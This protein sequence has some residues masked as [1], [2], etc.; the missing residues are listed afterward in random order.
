[1]LFILP[2]IPMTIDIF[3]ALVPTYTLLT[4][5]FIIGMS[6]LYTSLFN[7][8][9]L[10]AWLA[11]SILMASANVIFGMYQMVRILFSIS[12]FFLLRFCWITWRLLVR[13]T[14][15]APCLRG[16]H[17]IDISHLWSRVHGAKT[18]EEWCTAAR[19]IDLKNGAAAWSK[20]NQGYDVESILTLTLT[21]TLT[22]I[23]VMT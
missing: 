9:G 12:A 4:S 16:M 8:I 3:G 11:V 10:V 19:E 21:L 7:Y 1:M 20:D 17:R 23:K 2:E 22:L 13:V 15:W 18:Y 6:L 5:G 14:S